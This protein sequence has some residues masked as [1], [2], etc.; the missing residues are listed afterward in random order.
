MT[1]TATKTGR[2]FWRIV[3]SDTG[4]LIGGGT[5]PYASAELA[6]DAGDRERRERGLTLGHGFHT[7]VDAEVDPA[8]E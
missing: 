7:D 2:Y 4:R 8:G 5:I 6:R 1:A 3:H